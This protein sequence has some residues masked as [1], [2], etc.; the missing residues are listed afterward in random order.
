M[1]ADGKERVLGDEQYLN[2]LHEFMATKFAKSSSR[3]L[4]FSELDHL[5]VFARRLNDVAS[6]GVHA[7]VSAEEAKQ[8]LLGLYMFL[9][10]VTSRLERES[11]QETA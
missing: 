2:R 10:N 11:S 7:A 4:L 5:S 6:K 9:Y 3:D 1:C 8:G